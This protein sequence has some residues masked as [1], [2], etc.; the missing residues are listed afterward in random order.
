MIAHTVPF[1]RSLLTLPFYDMDYMFLLDYKS[2]DP[3]YT[4]KLGEPRHDT[5]IVDE[6]NIELWFE[7][8]SGELSAEEIPYAKWEDGSQ[9][10]LTFVIDFDRKLWVGFRWWNDQSALHDYQPRDWI[11]IEDNV[12]RYLPPD[13]VSRWDTQ[14]LNA[15]VFVSVNEKHH[16]LIPPNTRAGEWGAIVAGIDTERKKQIKLKITKLNGLEREDL[17]AV[18]ITDLPENTERWI[19]LHVSY[20]IS[21]GKQVSISANWRTKLMFLGEIADLG[22]FIWD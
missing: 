16:A 6:N 8:L 20:N 10:K 9:V 2:Y 12:F 1:Y 14:I 5:L 3:T 18:Q 21:Y 17:L 22:P 11:A 19:D 13:I 4:P 15:A 7:S